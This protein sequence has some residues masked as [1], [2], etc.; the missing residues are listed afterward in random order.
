MWTPKAANMG[1]TTNDIL[2]AANWSSES[3]FQKFY[4]KPTEKCNYGRAVLA[5]VSK[6]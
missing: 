5:K 4:H 2:K 3:V 6:K 1:V